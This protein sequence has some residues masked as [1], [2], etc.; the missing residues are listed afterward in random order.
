MRDAAP[1][2]PDDLDHFDQLLAKADRVVPMVDVFHGDRHDHTIG[3]R[4]DVDDNHGSLD[5]ALKLGEWEHARGYRATFY[6]LHDSHYW[7]NVHDAA[8]ELFELGHEVGI[9]VNAIGEAIRQNRDPKT[10]LSEALHHLRCAVPVVGMVAHGDPLC[11]QH[12]FVNDELFMECRRPTYGPASRTAGTVLID[13]VSMWEFGIKY[14]A[15]WIGRGDYL[16]DSGGR[17]SQPFDEVLEQWPAT[18]QLHIL[19]HPDW[20]ARAFQEVTV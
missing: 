3:L 15:N 5:T 16:S 8:R 20:W 18:G 19:Q 6:L 10:I 13:P 14:D 2:L 17:W 7:P 12:R 11:H 4:H 1:F 9:H